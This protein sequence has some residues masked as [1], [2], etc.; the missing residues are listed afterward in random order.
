MH[1]TKKIFLQ[2]LFIIFVY[3]S[4]LY[5][6]D[7][8]TSNATSLLRL[9]GS[10]CVDTNVTAMHANIKNKAFFTTDEA[11]YITSYSMEKTNYPVANSIA[12]TE[13]DKQKY[14]IKALIEI[15]STLSVIQD[16]NATSIVSGDKYIYL[17]GI[18]GVN[19]FS[20]DDKT[21]KLTG[22]ELNTT[23]FSGRSATLYKGTRYRYVFVADYGSISAIEI[24]SSKALNK[25]ISDPLAAIPDTAIM[26][27]Y[28]I[29]DGS[30]T[31]ISIYQNFLYVS[32]YTKS[33]IWQLQRYLIIEENNALVLDG[34]AVFNIKATEVYAN[35]G[36]LYT[37]YKP[38]DLNNSDSSASS[39][40]SYSLSNLNSPLFRPGSNRANIN[41]GD[42]YYR[43]E[44]G[45][46]GLVIYERGTNTIVASDNSFH[47]DKI[48]SIGEHIIVNDFQT[49]YIR[50]YKFG[51][52]NVKNTQG[53]APATVEF[54]IQKYNLQT[55]N[56]EFGDG[57]TYDLVEKNVQHLYKNP[58]NYEAII[59]TTYEDDINNTDPNSS[60]QLTNTFRIDLNIRNSSAPTVT[61]PI[62]I[63]EGQIPLTVDFNSTINYSGSIHRIEWD[64]GDGNKSSLPNLQHTY[65]AVG[66]YDVTLTAFYNSNSIVQERFTVKTYSSGEINVTY[67][68]NKVIASTNDLLDF[69]YTAPKGITDKNISSI[70]WNFGDGGT[71]NVGNSKHTYTSNGTYVI[72]LTIITNT[73]KIYT[74]TKTLS[75]Y[76][77]G[78]HYIEATPLIGESPLKVDFNIRTSANLV[79]VSFITNAVCYTSTGVV[80]YSDSFSTTFTS[81]GKKTVACNIRLS[82][83]SAKVIQKTIIVDDDIKLEVTP[84]TQKTSTEQSVTFSSTAT[85]HSGIKDIVWDFGDGTKSTSHGA[86]LS[87]IYTKAGF[88]NGIATLTTNKGHT[89]TKSFNVDVNL[90]KKVA[91]TTATTDNQKA[92]AIIYAKQINNNIYSH[93]FEAIISNYTTNILSY[94]WEFKPNIKSNINVATADY[95]FSNS[96]ASATNHTVY[97]KIQYKDNTIST[98]SYTVNIT[99][100]KISLSLDRGWNM[101]SAPVNVAFETTYDANSLPP[102]TLSMNTLKN[103]Y[104]SLV[105][106]FFNNTWTSN[107]NYIP[108]GVGMWVKSSINNNV[109]Y[110]N[111]GSSYT[112]NL[113][114]LE[115]NRWYLLGTGMDIVDFQ[116]RYGRYIAK[117]FIYAKSLF[118]QNP[119]FVKRGQGIW[120]LTKP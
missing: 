43:I 19:M 62:N 103:S 59:K 96:S 78:E 63:K 8:I 56:Y 4:F 94:W 47:G 37:T 99:N 102:G 82:D 16:T 119:Y 25:M 48:L 101:I 50:V 111:G 87:H 118:T 72:I 57:E 81:P 18:Y 53:E 45:Y 21:L 65:N 51:L 75:I 110:F 71:S 66:E 1:F 88:Y 70:R 114:R 36:Y 14:D 35:G 90:S 91:T 44:V 83:G 42:R 34:K 74:L 13:K 49:S 93:R 73:N 39:S 92:V 61:I 17:G 68:Q 113:S 15:N 95:T 52:I 30:I 26:G 120:I 23:V 80:S 3:N 20:Y 107:P 97:F 38:N 104:V 27:K 106:T 12:L 7:P 109:L 79:G 100:S 5:S 89:T 29:T 22:P 11:G 24:N 86:S 112:L 40:A 108:S 9:V 10:I 6:C 60:L 32:Y 46:G 2:F 85:T 76:A 69:T 116:N 77:D 41:V 64:L 33:N 84:L 28:P 98:Y 58:G 67:P 31:S 54:D 105:W 115:R 55:I 117:S